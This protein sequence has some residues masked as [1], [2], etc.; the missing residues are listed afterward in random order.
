MTTPTSSQFSTDLGGQAGV[1]AGLTAR[2]NRPRLAS[3]GAARVTVT[4]R[5]L[6]RRPTSLAVGNIWYVASEVW[7]KPR[8]KY[9][10]ISFYQ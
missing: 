7:I 9:F 4:R 10:M 5:C 6:P 8:Y 3:V 2:R 1:G